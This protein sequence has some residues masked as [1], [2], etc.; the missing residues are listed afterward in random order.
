MIPI[1]HG[2]LVYLNHKNNVCSTFLSCQSFRISNVRYNFRHVHKLVVAF[3]FYAGKFYARTHGK[4]TRSL[5]VE[6]HPYSHVTT[7]S[8]HNINYTN[9]PF[10]VCGKFKN[11]RR[12]ES[13]RRICKGK[14]LIEIKHSILARTSLYHTFT[15][16]NFYLLPKSNTEILPLCVIFAIST[17]TGN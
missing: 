15:I 9:V 7:S 1:N 3:P 16:S 17:K 4:I 14:R 8:K 13:F 5:W 6:I 2:C 11:P 10:L 12:G